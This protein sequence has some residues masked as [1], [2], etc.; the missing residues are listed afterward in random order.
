MAFGDRQ[1]DRMVAVGTVGPESARLWVR[2]PRPGRHEVRLWRR[3]ARGAP[4]RVR[5]AIS[6][7][8]RTDNTAG[9]VL[10]R[11]T[12]GAPVLEPATGYRFEV[13]RLPRTVVGRGRFETAPA[14]PDETPER[15]SVALMS[16]HQP[17]D[18]GGALSSRHMRLWSVLDRALRERDVKLVLMG[19]DQVYSD[20]PS[21]FSLFDEHYFESTGSAHPSIFDCGAEE[22]RRHYQGRYRTFWSMLALQ[23]LYAHYP[24]YPILDDHE[25]VDDWGCEPD[26]ERPAFRRLARGARHA[27]FDYQASR[28]RNRTAG[29]PRSF[30]YGFA[31]GSLA[32][33]VM[34]LRSERR[35]G[36]RINRLYGAD[37]LRDLQRFLRAHA[38][39][40]AVLIVT[41]VPVVHLPSWISDL[42][43]FLAGSKVDFPD[44]W[45]Y[46]RNTSARDGLLR[47]IHRHQVRHPE[48]RV[49]L[50]GGDVHIGCGFAIRWRGAGLPPL[51]QLTSSAVSNRLQS[52]KARIAS[53]GPTKV[54]K[55]QV[56]RG[57]PNLTADVRL[58]P[59][60]GTRYRR[61]PFTGLN[62]GIL[63]LRDR[64]DHTTLRYEL[65]GYDRRDGE[66]VP[67]TKFASPEL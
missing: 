5:F 53:L 7:D 58:L 12:L 17:F 2:S 39:R 35:V 60:A 40:R 13:V 59:A 51:Y 44:H 55:L 21:E 65:L 33:F 34:D 38:D 25:I 10:N 20:A 14:S 4:A 19:G 61:N 31:W 64:G 54:S 48:Q 67:V 26:H 50:V 63:E 42:G 6:A 56:T 23:R 32:V 16:C 11:R 30:H 62:V 45:S 18:S 49:A 52:V 66:T 29:L 41:S 9:V 36:S 47:V 24:T 46:E 27:Y 8:N 1:L 15:F 57:G 3:H 22:I 28:I 37:Q 43:G